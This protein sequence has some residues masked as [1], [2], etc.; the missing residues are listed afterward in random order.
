MRILRRE[1][2]VDPE[3]IKVVVGR[4]LRKRR[5][6]VCRLKLS[7]TV[8]SLS[9]EAANA[10][11]PQE[12]TRCDHPS[13]REKLS[14]SISEFPLRRNLRRRN[15][16]SIDPSFTAHLNRLSELDAVEPP[17][18]LSIWSRV[19]PLRR[20]HPYRYSGTLQ[21]KVRLHDVRVGPDDRQIG[22]I[23]LWSHIPCPSVY[24]SCRRS[25]SDVHAPMHRMHWCLPPPAMSLPRCWWSVD[26]AYRTR[27][28]RRDIAWFATY[29]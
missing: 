1:A 28:P 11:R 8:V 9:S 10:R 27:D 15:A 16:P 4:R 18:S 14:P 5:L 20:T 19:Q 2:L 24:P 7:C 17:I 22:R 25:T 3:L 21:R 6:S 12:S 13:P 23:R 29:A 26:H